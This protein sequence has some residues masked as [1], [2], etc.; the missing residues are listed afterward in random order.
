MCVF[1][2]M[3]V[4]EVLD[5][6]M[7]IF[8]LVLPLPDMFEFI[9]GAFIGIGDEVAIGIGVDMLEFDVT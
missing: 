1:E 6:F 9:I 5:E 3:C 2:F 7:G 8:P 4:F